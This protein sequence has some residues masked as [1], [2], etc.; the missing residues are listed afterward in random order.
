MNE[1]KPKST[2]G[3]AE[4]SRVFVYGTLMRGERAHAF[5]EGAVYEGEYRLRDYA[6]FD[7]GRYPG[8]IPRPG[9]CVFGEVYSVDAVMLRKMDE[10]EEEGSLYFRE[11]VTAENAAGELQ[12]FAYVYA[13][14]IKGE[15]IE[16]GSWKIR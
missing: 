15:L 8:I 14:E 9:C 6:I 4:K 12:A 3:G 11:T 13:S 7:L 2:A 5:L 1:A 16:S 10:Y